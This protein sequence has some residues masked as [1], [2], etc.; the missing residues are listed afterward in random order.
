MFIS[1]WIWVERLE[2]L[3]VTIADAM[4]VRRTAVSGMLSKQRR[5]GLSS[6]EKALVDTFFDRLTLANS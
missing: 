3:Q 4:C 5:E 2:R 1:A 6:E